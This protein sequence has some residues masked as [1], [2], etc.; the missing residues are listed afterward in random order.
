MGNTTKRALADAMKARLQ[1]TKLENITIKDITGDCN[2]NRQTFYYHFKDIYDLI[3]WI[4]EDEV[5]KLMEQSV[6]KESIRD[7]L[8]LCA[9]YYR[10]NEKTILHA[11][12]SMD[13]R[14][15]DMFLRRW[16]GPMIEAIVRERAEGKNISED[17][18]KFIIDFCTIANVGI[19]F[20]ALEN[21]MI[22][23]LGI[24]ANRLSVL[25]DG[26]IDDMISRFCK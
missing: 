13:R 6:G 9:D 2:L 24:Q 12:K 7:V 16:M 5:K 19:A 17:D 11:Y 22:D 23:E 10:V 1:K 14:F 26:S 4:F 20:E 18:V 21:G 3:E 8:L 25:L 15:L